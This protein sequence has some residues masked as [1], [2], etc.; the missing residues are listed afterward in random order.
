MK[1]WVQ[2]RNFSPVVEKFRGFRRP[3]TV[4]FAVVA[5]GAAVAD[6]GMVVGCLLEE[7]GRSQADPVVRPLKNY[8]S[9]FVGNTDF[10]SQNFITLHIKAPVCQ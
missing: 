7:W 4:L 5:V 10:W 2:Y 1:L 6:F 3:G 9:I 8:L